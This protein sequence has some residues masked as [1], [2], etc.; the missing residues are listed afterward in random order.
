MK[1][2]ILMLF[3]F[4][5]FFGAVTLNAGVDA[6]AP[7]V[8]AIQICD[9]TCAYGKALDPATAF[10]VKVVVD[11][12]NGDIDWTS[13]VLEFYAST[14]QNGGSA[15][16]D[17]RILTNLTYASGQGCTISDGGA[18]DTNCI[19][20]LASNWTTKFASG[21]MNVFFRIRDYNGSYDANS[22]VIATVNT[23]KGI[24]QVATTGSWTALTA[25]TTNNA[26]SADSNAYIHTIH[27][28]NTNINVACTAT[29]MTSGANSITVG[30]LAWKNT[31]GA[32][33]TD[34]TGGADAIQ[35]AWTRGTD[36]TPASFGNYIWLDVPIG[37]K[38]GTYT[39]SLTYGT[40]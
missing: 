11:E 24:S 25:N 23:S 29:A 17:H 38:S 7:K 28:G 22:G 36:P 39:G 1:K 19:T 26:I 3:F 16:W 31:A 8:R 32:P 37:T 30:N 20:V 14:D 5:T 13:G 34:F 6:S 21:D 9:G 2:I 4:A 10:T 15:D 27:N 18:T 35:T 12:N 33:G 40:S